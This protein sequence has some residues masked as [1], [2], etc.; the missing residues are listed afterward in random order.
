MI[1]S[2][3]GHLIGMLTGS[4]NSP[5]QI[6]DESFSVVFSSAEP[7]RVDVREEQKATDFTI[8]TGEF[9]ILF[10]AM[11]H[12]RNRRNKVRSRH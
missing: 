5:I 11:I 3:A 12:D 1:G 6:L 10:K 4:F 8:E 7:M 9:I 2:I